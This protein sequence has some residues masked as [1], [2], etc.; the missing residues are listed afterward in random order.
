[1]FKVMMSWVD[2]YIDVWEVSFDWF[3]MLLQLDDCIFIKGKCYD[4]K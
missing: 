4:C 2:Y 3:D 1:M